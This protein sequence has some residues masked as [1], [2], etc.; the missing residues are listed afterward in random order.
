MEAEQP[1]CQQWK[2]DLICPN[3]KEPHTRYAAGTGTWDGYWREPKFYD[4]KHNDWCGDCRMLYLG[5]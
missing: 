2:Q 4:K 5:D 1:K 3:C